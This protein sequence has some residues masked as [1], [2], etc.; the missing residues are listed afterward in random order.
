MNLNPEQAVCEMVF[1]VWWFCFLPAV[2][3]NIH[4]FFHNDPW[5]L[6]S[7]ER[8][9]LKDGTWVITVK[10]TLTRAEYDHIRQTLRGRGGFES[11]PLAPDHI[12]I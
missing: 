9:R 3:W 5:K 4:D 10:P 12:T 7:A 1:L 11:I 2:M 6:L 8:R